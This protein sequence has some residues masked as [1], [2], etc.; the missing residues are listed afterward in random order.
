MILTPVHGEQFVED[1]MKETGSGKN[2]CR[3]R[4]LSPVTKA[5]SLSVNGIWSH[6]IIL[7]FELFH[8]SFMDHFSN[9]ESEETNKKLPMLFTKAHLDSNSC[10]QLQ[11]FVETI[12]MFCMSDS[13][14]G[15]R[16]K[17]VESHEH[18]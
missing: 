2:L 6:F 11:S 10:I 15:R 14:L 9:M 7:L 5:L 16:I 1:V 3:G 4:Q 12:W 13:S 17:E 18:V 8:N